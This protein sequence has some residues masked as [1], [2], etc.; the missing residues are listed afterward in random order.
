MRRAVRTRAG[1]KHLL[2]FLAALEL[3]AACGRSQQTTFERPP[4]P[5]TTATAVARDVPVYIDAVGK[6]V[7]REVVSIQP[8]VSGR[9]TK[10]H[11]VDGANLKV[12]DLL[13]TIDPRPY[14]AQL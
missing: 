10:I 4:A 11:F 9:I 14:Q 3:A 13:F 2:G 6:I 1:V 5:V 7:A 8:Q 12:G